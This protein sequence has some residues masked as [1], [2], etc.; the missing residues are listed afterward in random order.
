M[1]LLSKLASEREFEGDTT[2][3]TAAH[4]RVRE[5]SSTEPVYKSSAEASFERSLLNTLI[6]YT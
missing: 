6:L 1:R 2:R 4:F 5:D 3:R